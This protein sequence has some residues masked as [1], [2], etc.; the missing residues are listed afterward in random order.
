MCSPQSCGTALVAQ[1]QCGALFS[2]SCGYMALS[3]S[4]GRYVMLRFPFWLLFCLSHLQES[5]FGAM[6]VL[7]KVNKSIYTNLSLVK[8][9]CSACPQIWPYWQWPELTLGVKVHHKPWKVRK[10]S[11]IIFV[12]NLQS[13][14]DTFFTSEIFFPEDITLLWVHW[15]LDKMIWEVFSNFKHSMI[16]PFRQLG[17]SCPNK[18]RV[19]LLHAMKLL[20]CIL[21]VR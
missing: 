10:V 17:V 1:L 15:G 13:E 4:T 16:Q 7:H 2:C 9:F 20:Q 19:S 3:C 21:E 11:N 12:F 8:L 14:K 6:R 18:L 5:H